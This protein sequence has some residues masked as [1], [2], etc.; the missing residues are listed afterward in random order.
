MALVVPSP[1]YVDLYGRVQ[2]ALS[3]A[4]AFHGTLYRAC[5]P[6]YAN[7]R[8]LLTGEGSRKVGGRWNGP[9]SFATVYLAQS[10]DGSIAES[11]GL[12]GVFG[13]DPAKRLPLTLVAVEVRLQ[14]VL[15]LTDARVRRI[16]G[17]AI[18]T[19]NTCDWRG[20]N[21]VGKE[22]FT[23]ALGP[24]AFELNVHGIIVPSAVKRSFRNLNVF[25]ANLATA[26]Q[27]IILRSDK[28][29]SPPRLM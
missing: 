4:A 25:P 3:T 18:N 7:T 6:T 23:Q 27:L 12:P 22:S 1:D 11:L 19:M 24:A 8:D 13:F 10:V 28:L 17:I 21:A 9:G 2:R 29:P 14:V 26:G 20:E 5:D 15:D 16:L